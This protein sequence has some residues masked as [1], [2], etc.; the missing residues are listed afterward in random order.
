M[1]TSEEKGDAVW[2]GETG[3]FKVYSWYFASKAGTLVFVVLLFSLRFF[4]KLQPTTSRWQG[5]PGICSL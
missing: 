1:S 3:D 2:E 5:K 4:F